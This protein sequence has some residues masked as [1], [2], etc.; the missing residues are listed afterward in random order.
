MTIRPY[1]IFMFALT[2]VFSGCLGPSLTHEE[3]LIYYAN[4][5]LLE[6]EGKRLSDYGR[7]YF[8][9][10]PKYPGYCEV[11]F[12]IPEVPPNAPPMY[13]D[14]D[15]ALLMSN[16]SVIPPK[17]RPACRRLEIDPTGK[18]IMLPPITNTK[19]IDP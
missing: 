14:I 13:H 2:F 11:H 6:Q 9:F 16:G 7:Y 8:H 4:K 12:A 19:V 17:E 3:K 15:L 18:C 5:F 10:F 1:L